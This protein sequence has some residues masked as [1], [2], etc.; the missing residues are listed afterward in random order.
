M[1]VKLQEY[2][3]K[4]AEFGSITKA[5]EQLFITQ[6]ALDQQLL[7]LEKEL[8]ITL[9]N[10]SKN[11]MTLTEAGTVY[12]KYA[13][14]I[15]SLKQEAYNRI[16]DIADRKS[17]TLLI[18]L[19]PERGMNMFINIYPEFYREYPDVKIIPREIGVAHQL[20]MLNND[21]LDMGF[22]ATS[23]VTEPKLQTIPIMEEKLVLA[24]P[25]SHALASRANPQGEDLAP[26]D[27]SLF[28][29][30]TFVCIFQESTQRRLIDPLFESAGFKPNILL[31]TASN[32]TMISMVEKGLACCIGP[33]YYTRGNSG[34]ACFS[35]GGESSW[36]T[37]VCYKKNRY[38]S[39]AAQH[40]IQLAKYYSNSY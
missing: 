24:V 39:Q 4:I 11:D 21:M 10:R 40:L 30:D 33:E 37:Q 25:K 31:E 34:I 3:L 8:G 18:G 9:F 27:L 14:E 5:A 7:K 35:L 17:G 28:K 15:V 12:V 19:M 1:N 2:I 23:K 16:N 32:K 6:S 13:R 26:I 22:I 20:E 29:D 36:Y 38:L